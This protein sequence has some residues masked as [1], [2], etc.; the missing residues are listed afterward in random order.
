MPTTRGCP[1]ELVTIHLDV[2]VTVDVQDAQAE[3]P[4]Q[5]A[6]TQLLTELEFFSL[7][8]TLVDAPA[9]DLALVPVP[10]RRR[11]TRQPPRRWRRHA[12]RAGRPRRLHVIPVIDDPGLL[13]GIV[14]RLREAP[15]VALDD[16]DQCALTRAERN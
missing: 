3:E 7:V 5:A 1:S 15:L 12:P 16:R 11:R 2:P 10:S 4:D 6:L 13:P 9:A 14:A 8:K